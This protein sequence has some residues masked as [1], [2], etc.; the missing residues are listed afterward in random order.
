[1]YRSPQ[2]CAAAHIAA[3]FT[4]EAGGN[5]FLASARQVSSQQISDTL[6]ASFSE[7]EEKTPM[8][9][10]GTSSLPEKSKQYDANSAKT[11]NVLGIEFRSV[12]DTFK[13]L[14]KQLLSLE[15][16]GE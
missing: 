9:K 1:M 2:D 15:K 8:G 6:R 5:R 11:K 12:E 10:P 16:N 3:I 13:D 14:G 4:P 7:L